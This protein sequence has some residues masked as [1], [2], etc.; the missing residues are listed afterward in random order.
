MLPFRL[1][2]VFCR[3]RVMKVSVLATAIVL[4]TVNLMPWPAHAA[5]EPQLGP[6][7]SAAATSGK[8]SDQAEKSRMDV[9]KE[10]DTQKYQEQSTESAG[11]AGHR[12][13]GSGPAA[14]K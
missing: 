12:Q 5:G 8:S 2:Q 10:R 9:K 1:L 7:G 3:E 6:Q 14:T 13:A 4:S 11:Q